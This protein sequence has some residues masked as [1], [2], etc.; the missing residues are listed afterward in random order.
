MA[1]SAPTSCLVTT[2][3]FTRGGCLIQ[4]STGRFAVLG[5]WNCNK[6]LCQ[7][8]M[9]TRTLWLYNPRVEHNVKLWENP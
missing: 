1:T 5:I 6:S 3:M 9:N 7:L 4:A 8:M 2:N